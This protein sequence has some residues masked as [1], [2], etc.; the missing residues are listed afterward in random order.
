VHSFHDGTRSR[1]FSVN[2]RTRIDAWGK[3]GACGPGFDAP[4]TNA[5]RIA[6]RR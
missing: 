5:C 6:D 2:R 4:A 3:L 1:K